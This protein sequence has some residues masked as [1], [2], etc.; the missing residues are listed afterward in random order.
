MQSAQL[1]A[2]TALQSQA[3]GS[4]SKGGSSAALQSARTSQQQVRPAIDKKG[5]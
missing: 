5:I 1:A 3:H 4:G 2:A